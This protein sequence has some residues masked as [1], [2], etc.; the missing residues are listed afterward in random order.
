MKEQLS[1]SLKEKE[2]LAAIGRALSS[3]KRLK[4]LEILREEALNINE[5]AQRLKIP[6]SSAAMHVKNLEEAGLIHTELMPG[7]RGSMKVCR[8]AVENLNIILSVPREDQEHVET[9]SMPIGNFVDYYVEATC[10][11]VGSDGYL[12]EEDEPRCFYNPKR[13][14]AQL[15]WFGRGYVEYRFPN[16]TLRE[17]QLKKLE[18]SAELCSE[19]ADYNMDY[20][21]DITLWI[22]GVEAGTW[23]CPSDFGGRRGKLNPEWWL[24]KNTQYG[25]LKI[26]SI[27]NKGSKLDDEQ[28]A[29]RKINDYHLSQSPY[30][31]VR[32]GIKEDAQHIGG[33]NI[34]GEKFG[35]FPQNIVMKFFY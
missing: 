8:Q 7:I 25:K 6:Q 20:P 35:D 26:W 15:I 30:I 33:V 2:R 23:S 10:G 5:I 22:N 32:I 28:I 11:I 27:D 21:S 4:L 12:D 3:E 34:F 1:L 16:A 19:V 31:S 18:V 17:G 24:D 13:A 14:T 29:D 9:I